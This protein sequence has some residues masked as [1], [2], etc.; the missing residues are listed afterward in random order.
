M[1]G[2]GFFDVRSP[3]FVPV[4]RRVAVVALTL[5]WALFELANGAPAW[6]MIFGAAGLWCGYQFFVVWE[7]PQD[8]TGKDDR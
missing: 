2:R 1:A 8:D 5:G 4:W 6:A 7:P 3:F